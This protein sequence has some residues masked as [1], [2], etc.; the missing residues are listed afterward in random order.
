MSEDQDSRI[1][2]MAACV[3]A[4]GR[5]VARSNYLNSD[6]IAEIAKRTYKDLTG[7]DWVMP[8]ETS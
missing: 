1:V 6:S 3:K 8:T 4:A 2:L 7:E 5:V